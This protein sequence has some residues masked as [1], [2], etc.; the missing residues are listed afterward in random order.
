MNKDVHTF[1]KGICLKVNEMAWL[2]FELINLD[3][4]VEQNGHYSIETHP[5]IYV[6]MRMYECV[7]VCARVYMDM[8]M[9]ARHFSLPFSL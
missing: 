2:E 1:P 6:Y 5:D 7:C 4:A 8:C 9:C 3:I